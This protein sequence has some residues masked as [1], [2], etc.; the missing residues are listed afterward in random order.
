MSKR[1]VPKGRKRPRG[2][3]QETASADEIARRLKESP[4]RP[5][6]RRQPQRRAR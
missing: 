5:K 3:G 6:R 4:P 1:Q 2:Y